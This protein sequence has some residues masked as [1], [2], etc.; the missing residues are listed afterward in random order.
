MKLLMVSGDNSIVRG[1]KGAFY[2]TL[3]EFHKYWDRIDIICPKTND[4]KVK[5]IF[6]NVFFHVSNRPKL[7]QGSFIYKKGLEIFKTHKFDIITVQEYPPFYNSYGAG[8]LARKTKRPYFSEW[9][10]IIGYPKAAGIKEKIYFDMTKKKVKFIGKMADV[11]RVVNKKQVPEFLIKHGVPKEKIKYIPSFYIDLEIFKQQDMTKIYDL[12][13]AA[14]LEKNK[15]IFNLIKA[16]QIIK[17]EMPEI[18]L[19]IIGSGSQKE[20]LQ[21]YINKKSLEQNVIFSGWLN[22]AD[23]VARAYNSAKIFVNPSFNEGGPRV[24]LEAM[25]CGLPAVTT[26][27]GVALDIVEDPSTGSGQ[28]PEGSGQATGIFIDW[29]AKDM[30]EKIIGLLEDEK[31]IEKIGQ[32]GKL[33]AQQFEK[34]AMIKNYAQKIKEI[35]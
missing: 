23:D 9:H 35:A 10:H 15:G 13:F 5:Q 26:R 28:A 33:I 30:A 24:L 14:R 7:L 22:S 16:V 12:V 34:K 8:K 1:K 32:A 20:K 4:V 27:V 21:K 17:K 29:K 19:L 31:Q 2:N 25:A 11:V 3:S 18:K 6:G